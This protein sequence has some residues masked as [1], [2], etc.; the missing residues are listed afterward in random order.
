MTLNV[1]NYTKTTDN[2]YSPKKTEQVFVSFSVQ[3]VVM[4]IYIYIYCCHGNI[5]KQPN[6]S[7]HRFTK[8]CSSMEMVY[9]LLDK[10]LP[11]RT[12]ILYSYSVTLAWP[13]K[14]YFCRINLTE[15]RQK[16]AII[17]LKCDTDSNVEFLPCRI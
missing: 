12:N 4:E 10:R 8:C 1:Q 16:S 7:S 13:H 3:F 15:I 6:A 9:L 11:L 14:S 2:S 17:R 5:Y